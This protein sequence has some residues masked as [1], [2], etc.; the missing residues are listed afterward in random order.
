VEDPHD[1]LEHTTDERQSD[2]VC[3]VVVDDRVTELGD[4]QRHD[5]GRAEVDVLGRAEQEVDEA[6][7]EGRVQSVLA[8]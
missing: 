6:R 1:D 4:E 7:H 3:G 2:G 5:G 8:T